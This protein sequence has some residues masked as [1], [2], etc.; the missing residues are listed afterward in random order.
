VLDTNNAYA[1]GT[2]TIVGGTD[3]VAVSTAGGSPSVLV[4]N[5]GPVGGL[6]ADP[7]GVFWMANGLMECPSTGCNQ[8]GTKIANVSGGALTA[9][10]RAF[11]WGTG[12]GFVYLLAR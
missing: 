11:A 6:F 4:P 8:M 1:L 7:T 2:N 5:V 3:L 10:A 12:S 9:D